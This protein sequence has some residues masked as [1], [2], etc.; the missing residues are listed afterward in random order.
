MKPLTKIIV[1]SLIVIKVVLGSIFVYH[2]E[3]DP[4]FLETDAI[5][6]TDPVAATDAMVTETQQDNQPI[7]KTTEEVNSEGVINLNILIKKSEAL[8]V[9][10][11]Q[12]AM[13]EEE[14]VIIQNEINNKIKIL[15]KLRN[16]INSHAT[17]KSTTEE[18]KLK[19]LIKV[20]SSMKPQ[21]AAGLIEKL[22]MQFAIE[23]LSNMKGEAVGNIL[24]FVSIEKAAKISEGLAANK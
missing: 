9:K 13:K 20:Y 17:N 21:R 4:I 16:E 22:D 23:L 8:K 5:A 3:F 14:L 18:K 1:I 24:S 15:S 6:A 7:T 10:E 2:A 12:L 19:H 11:E